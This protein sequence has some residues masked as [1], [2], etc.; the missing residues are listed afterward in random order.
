MGNFNSVNTQI[1]DTV[2]MRTPQLG[3]LNIEEKRN[4]IERVDVGQ[5]A[6]ANIRGLMLQNLNDVTIKTN[7]IPEV[8]V[9]TETTANF[10]GLMNLGG[11]VTIKTNHIPEVNV[12]KG[13]TGNFNGL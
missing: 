4:H 5:G 9:A 7:H 12:G 10:N 13:A 11:S 3:P 2:T 1:D 8:N 6:T